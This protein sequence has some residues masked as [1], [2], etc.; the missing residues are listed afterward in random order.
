MDLAITSPTT[1]SIFR[2]LSLLGH[3]RRLKLARCSAYRAFEMGVRRGELQPRQAHELWKRLQRVDERSGDPS[4]Q[5]EGYGYLSR[6]AETPQRID[7][8]RWPTPGLNRQGF[9]ELYRAIRSGRL[10]QDQLL[11]KSW[12][13]N[14]AQE[15]PP[16]E[17]A[18]FLS[19]LALLLESGVAA[20]DAFDGVA[21][22]QC[23]P[24]ARQLQETIHEVVARQGRPLSSALARFPRVVGTDALCLLRAGEAG[25]DLVGGLRRA[26]QLIEERVALRESV[27]RALSGP[28]MSLLF[29][30][31]ILMTVVAFVMPKFLP[32]YDQLG[33]R[34]PLLSQ[35]ILTGVKVL[36]HPLTQLALGLMLMLVTFYREQ[37]RDSLYELGL[38]LPLLKG[39]IGNLRALQFSQVMTQLCRQGVPLQRGLSL[40][41]EACP[42]PSERQRLTEAAE[43]YQESGLLTEA[44]RP[45]DHLP[46]MLHSMCEVGEETGR[47]PA[48][49]SSLHR[50]LELQ[51]KL[52]TA[53]ALNLLEPLVLLVIGSTMG[54]LF[55]GLFLPIYGMLSGAGL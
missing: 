3:R 10:T 12:D 53:Q 55:I 37:L 14:S 24:G 21:G 23:P 48:L 28:L 32:I 52:S 9:T 19:R 26:S 50:L 27:K 46:R 51:V 34:L 4:F 25:G 22:P 47:L 15:L 30:L 2:N 16:L 20:L 36:G 8:G 40:L 45:L 41:A 11:K 43:R 42:I 38:R 5:L 39:W 54:T 49:L 17:L 1:P 44:L 18:R 35:L 7:A 29:G 6:L 33:G 31:L 13:G